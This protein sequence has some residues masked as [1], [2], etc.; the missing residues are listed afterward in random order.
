MILFGQKPERQCR[1]CGCTDSHACVTAAG[2]CCWVLE[3]VH[4][5]TGICSACAIEL[6]FAQALFI[7]AGREDAA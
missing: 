4:T 1:A 7:F 3:D 2:P 6:D 5:P